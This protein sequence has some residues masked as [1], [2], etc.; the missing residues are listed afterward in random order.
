MTRPLL[1]LALVATLLLAFGPAAAQEPTV[2]RPASF[3]CTGLYSAGQYRDAAGCFESLEAQG[4]LNGHLL[5]NVGNARYRSGEFGR[6]ILAYQRARLFLPRDGDLKANLGSARD[7]AK[8]DLPPPGQREG[9]ARALLGPF[10]ALSA[11][12]LLLLGAIAWALLFV[13][14]GVRLHRPFAGWLALAVT[15]GLVAS[16]GLGGWAAR[17][18]SVSR[19]PVA[20]VLVEEVTLRS[21]RDVLSTDLAR[22]HEG[23][24][25]KVV[26]QTDDWVQVTLST[27]PRGWL[28]SGA[29]GLVRHRAD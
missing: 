27:G 15:A 25:A 4:H 20:V 9:L 17:S 12:E 24:E 28:P 14:L 22:L 11:S 21:G 1:L 10:D 8:D 23:A 19:H 2:A 5:Y 18:Y 29:V 13:T 26:E 16:A 3:D 6:A 7:Q